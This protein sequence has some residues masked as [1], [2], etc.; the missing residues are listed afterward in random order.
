MSDIKRTPA[1]SSLYKAYLDELRYFIE[2]VLKKDEGA[3][4]YWRSQIRMS[5]EILRIV[6]Q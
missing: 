5:R 3:V 6:T 2:A 4:A 1:T